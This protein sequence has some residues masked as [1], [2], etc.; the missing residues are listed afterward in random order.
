MG[1][2]RKKG[3][4]KTVIIALVLAFIVITITWMALKNNPSQVN[5]VLNLKE[6]YIKFNMSFYQ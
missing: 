2:D 5:F 3:L 1:A 6:S 4:V